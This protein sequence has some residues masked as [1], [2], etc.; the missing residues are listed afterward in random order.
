MILNEV[1]DKCK[2]VIS[3]S[4]D[5]TEGQLV[6]IDKVSLS[7]ENETELRTIKMLSNG[8]FKDMKLPEAGGMDINNLFNSMF[9]DYSYKL[10][11]E[12]SG[13]GDKL[14]IKIPFT[15]EN[16]F[17]SLYSVDDLFVGNVTIIGIYKGKIKINKLKNSFEFFREVGQ[18]SNNELDNEVHN[19]QYSQHNEIKLKNGE[20][21]TEYSYIDLLAIV[22]DIK[23]NQETSTTIEKE[24]KKNSK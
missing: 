2:T 5:I 7:L 12:I 10:K 8:M 1:M 16:E 22:Q 17:E 4:N 14:I 21:N 6:R 11:G 9:K 19:S 20:D 13:G 18:A 3:F 15:F 23:P 24:G